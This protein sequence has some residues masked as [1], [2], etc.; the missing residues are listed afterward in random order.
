M[1]F[2]A[3]LFTVFFFGVCLIFGGYGLHWV[4]VQL[5]LKS[6]LGYEPSIYHKHSLI[7][8]PN[9]KIGMNREFNREKHHLLEDIRGRE[10][11]PRPA[12]GRSMLIGG[13]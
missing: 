9:K 4:S 10:C 8:L 3:L 11:L 1:L 12:F 2:H 6:K 7:R 13:C 5:S